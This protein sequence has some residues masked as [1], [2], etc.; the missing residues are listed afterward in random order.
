MF[1]VKLKTNAVMIKRG[2]GRAHRGAGRESV[3][4]SIYSHR[5][6]VH[7]A[8]T[9]VP[10]SFERTLEGARLLKAARREGELRQRADEAERWTTTRRCKALA[11]DIGVGFMVDPDDHA[12]DGRRP[13]DPRPE[14]RRRR[15]CARVFRDTELVDDA[16]DFCAPPAGPLDA[17]DA[18]DT[19][20][21]S[22]G[23][24]SC[25]VSPYGDVYPCVQFPLPSGN[26][27]ADASSSTSGATRRSWREVRSITLGDLAGLLV[28]RAR[29]SCSRCPGLAY[30]EGNMRGPSTQDC[31]KSFARTGLESVNLKSKHAA[32][33]A[34]R[35]N[36]LAF[37]PLDQLRTNP[38]RRLQ[39]SVS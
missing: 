8:I 6:D 13:L 5:P 25:Y 38:S 31:E 2:A 12:D 33:A 10:G 4:I 16:E 15:S 17:E 23:H 3:Q 7:D 9:M 24:S 18:F 32:A 28:V 30:M 29:Q 14:H 11:D 39:A 27:R 1:S 36:T 22:A 19:M 35:A 21:C 37:I 34:P 26:V 20:P